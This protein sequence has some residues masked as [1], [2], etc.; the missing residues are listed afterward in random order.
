RYFIKQMAD[1][2]RA[3]VRKVMLWNES[4]TA[5]GADLELIKSTG[6]TIFCWN[7]CQRGAAVAASLGL[8]AVI[9]EWGSGCYYINRKQHNGESE[10][11]AAGHGGA[12]D[13]LPAVY[14][15]KPVPDDVTD[16]EQRRHYTGVQ[17][18]FWTE[19]VS[20]IR[21]CDYLAFPRLLAVAEA[22]WSPEEKKDF[23]SLRTRFEADIPLL[24][25]TGRLYGKHFIA[26]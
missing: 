15:Y 26:K 7:P 3:R 5:G 10:P 17:A 19:H 9:T 12:G 16:P 18:T 23:E 4:V 14:A 13:Q 1:H 8:D 20:D 24:D 25:M 11:V 21:Y 2:I 6:A 22:A